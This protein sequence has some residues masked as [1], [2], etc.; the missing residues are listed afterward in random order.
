MNGFIVGSRNGARRR[1]GG[2]LGAERLVG[3]R[4]LLRRGGL[5]DAIVGGSGCASGVVA[6]RGGDGGGG[7]GDRLRCEPQAMRRTRSARFTWHLPPGS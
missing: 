6:A 3:E 5:R 7:A 2:L 1:G 4:E